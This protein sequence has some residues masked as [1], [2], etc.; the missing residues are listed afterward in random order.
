MQPE[1][2]AVVKDALEAQIGGIVRG[3]GVCLTPLLAKMKRYFQREGASVF[4]PLFIFDF[5]RRHSIAIFLSASVDNTTPLSNNPYH[6]PTERNFSNMSNSIPVM[7]KPADAMSKGLNSSNLAA[8]A[9]QRHPIDR[10]QKGRFVRFIAAIDSY[11]TYNNINLTHQ[12]AQY[13]P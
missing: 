13:F 6:R 4:S 7:R 10:M 2:E 1:G 12:M 3:Q 5:I 8:A 9:Q 11:C